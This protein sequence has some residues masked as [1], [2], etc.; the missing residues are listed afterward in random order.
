[1]VVRVCLSLASTPGSFVHCVLVVRVY[2]WVWPGFGYG[3]SGEF[4]RYYSTRGWGSLLVVCVCLSLFLSLAS[5]PSSFIHCVLVVQVYVWMWPGVGHGVSGDFSTYYSTRGWGRL[6]TRSPFDT[7][8]PEDSAFVTCL[9]LFW[10]P[11]WFVKILCSWFDWFLWPDV[12]LFFLR[13][14]I[15][16][17]LLWFVS[18]DINHHSAMQSRRRSRY[19]DPWMGCILR[20]KLIALDFRKRTRERMGTLGGNH[21]CFRNSLSQT[22]NLI[23]LDFSSMSPR[24]PFFCCFVA[25]QPSIRKF[26]GKPGP[27]SARLGDTPAMDLELKGVRTHMYRPKRYRTKHTSINSQHGFT[28]H[29]RDNNQLSILT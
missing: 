28:S 10:F 12:G 2:V 25:T 1:L 17:R 7:S 9:D 18:V 20:P 29:T 19:R 22:F 8:S 14:W 3:V 15:W 4:I 5:T 26:E 24:F 11:H 16:T 27:G 6:K 13:R 21:I 23:R